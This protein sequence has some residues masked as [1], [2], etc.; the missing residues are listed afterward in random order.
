MIK[1]NNIKDPHP[2]IMTKCKK[3]K[4]IY[5]RKMKWHMVKEDNPATKLLK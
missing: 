2:V 1:K 3:S 5:K 4:R